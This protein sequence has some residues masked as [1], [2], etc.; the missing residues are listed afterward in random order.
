MLMLQLMMLL[1]MMMLILKLLMLI[2]ILML[3]IMWLILWLLMLLLLM[4]FLN[5]KTH[6]LLLLFK[7]G[8]YCELR[9]VFLLATIPQLSF[10]LHFT[11]PFVWDWFLHQFSKFLF[12]TPKLRY[13]NH[14]MGGGGGGGGDKHYLMGLSILIL[15][16]ILIFLS[17]LMILSILTFTI[18]ID[19]IINIDIFINFNWYFCQLSFFLNWYFY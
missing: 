5:Y 2:L 15:L 7:G 4:P 10:V 8:T 1:L 14:Q 18:Y 3:L 6:N 11:F 16:S 13:Q 9:H 19:K 12:G 17:I